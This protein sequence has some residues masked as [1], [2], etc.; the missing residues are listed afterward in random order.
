MK[1]ETKALAK[2]F[3]KEGYEVRVKGFDFSSEYIY[4]EASTGD[5]DYD[6]PV[7]AKIRV[8]DHASPLS[9]G[10][11][12]IERGERFFAADLSIDPTTALHWRAVVE[13]FK[14]A[15]ATKDS[16]FFKRFQK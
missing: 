10:G 6:Y 8:S 12:S 3:K 4:V 5:G 14:H 1:K 9:G 15:V 11:Y 2:A 7:E 13:I 16:E